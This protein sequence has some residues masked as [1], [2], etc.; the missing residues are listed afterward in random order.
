MCDSPPEAGVTTARPNRGSAI[1][2]T[3]SGRGRVPGDQVGSPG[4]VGADSGGRHR[5][6]RRPAKV[7][8]ATPTAVSSDAPES[9][10]ERRIAAR[11]PALANHDAT[12]L[13][14]PGAKAVDAMLLKAMSSVSPSLFAACQPDTANNVQTKGGDAGSGLPPSVVLRTAS[15]EEKELMSEQRSCTPCDDVTDGWH[16]AVHDA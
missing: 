13:I 12:P 8:T 6:R 4:G 1:D 9:S 16:H 15:A 11:R 3:P 10:A 7:F 5:A 2:G 14:V